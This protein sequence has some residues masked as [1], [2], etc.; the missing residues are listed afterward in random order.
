MKTPLAATTAALVVLLALVTCV[1]FAAPCWAEDAHGGAGHEAGHSTNP[2]SP[3]FV[4]AIGT[5]VVFLLLVVIL[6]KTAW[7][8]IL[9]GL[10]AREDGIREQIQ[11]AEKANA[12]AKG[13]L[14]EYQG[15]LAAAADE[16]KKAVDD[17]RKHAEELA[18][19]IE[20]D[21]K[22]EAGKER[23][24]A[25][26]D[27]EL[28]RQGAIKDVYDQVAAVATEVAGKILQQRLD[29]AQHRRLVEDGFAQLERRRKAPGGRA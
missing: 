4:V 17:G 27:I 1:A 12:D 26:R 8:P 18:A 25:L 6:G 22:A 24:R 7:K 2:L 15:K 11:G 23:E 29:P 5:V 10:K 20:A 16:A 13:L 9:A 3:D 14:T 21:A 19:R 28:A